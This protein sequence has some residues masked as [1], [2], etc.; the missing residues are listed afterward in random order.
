MSG[1]G[2]GGYFIPANGIETKM[3]TRDM[4][5]PKPVATLTVK[6]SARNL[7]KLTFAISRLG[8]H[9][10]TMIASNSPTLWMISEMLTAL[11]P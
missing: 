10:A 3:E 6:M 1:F 5:A 9:R 8:S 11:N 4:T 2:V 7:F